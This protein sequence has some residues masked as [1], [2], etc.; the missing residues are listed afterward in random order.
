LTS[1]NRAVLL[2]VAHA[3]GALRDELVFAGGQVAELLVTDPAA[4]RVRPTDDVDVISE[5]ATLSAY[6]QLG[7]RLRELGF[8]EEVT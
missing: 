1:P 3:L 4:G 7:E 6:H 5:V 2:R 8:R